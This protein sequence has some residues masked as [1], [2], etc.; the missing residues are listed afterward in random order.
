MF[1]Y[2]ETKSP[3]ISLDKPDET[4]NGFTSAREEQQV[5]MTGRY[6]FDYFLSF[7]FEK[8]I[9]SIEEALLVGS[10]FVYFEKRK[11]WTSLTK[12]G[13]KNWAD[14]NLCSIYWHR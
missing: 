1:T 9:Y 12:I 14:E 7:F 10:R 13:E 3:S 4:G 6:D 2:T 8:K 5:S 11:S